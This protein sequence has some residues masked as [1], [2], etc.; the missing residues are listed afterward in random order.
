MSY[1]CQCGNQVRDT[2]RWCA[3]CGTAQAAAGPGAKRAAPHIEFL[4]GLTSRNAVL[5]CYIPMVGWVAAIVVLASDRFRRD[6]EVRFHAFQGLYLFVTWLVVDWV[7][8]PMR[9][10][11]G[12]WG[13][14]MVFPGL[15]KLAVLGVWIYMLVKVSQG[16]LVRLPV[17]GD[18]A[19]RSVSEQRQ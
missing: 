8:S 9:M 12:I 7:L 6:I 3:V 17:L 19:E 2:D 4:N 16:E 14:H 1:C 10:D 15:L 18:L 13:M 5:L 11:W